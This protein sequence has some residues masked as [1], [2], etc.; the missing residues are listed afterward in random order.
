MQQN[1]VDTKKHSKSIYLLH[2]MNH[3]LILRYESIIRVSKYK[4]F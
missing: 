3:N 4:I 2:T 1:K